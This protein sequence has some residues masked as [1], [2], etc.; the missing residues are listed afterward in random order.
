MSKGSIKLNKLSTRSKMNNAVYNKN[1][2][3]SKYGNNKISYKDV[4]K[5][6]NNSIKINK[7]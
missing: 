1:T 5:S 7:D 2:A 4:F 3:S 6:S